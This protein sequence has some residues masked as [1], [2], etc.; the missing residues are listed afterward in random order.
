MPIQRALEQYLDP[1]SSLSRAKI[2]DPFGSFD[3]FDK[4]NGLSA[5]DGLG[6]PPTTKGSFP[7]AVTV[8]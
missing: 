5:V 2:I 3:P 4:N 6:K 7:D 8:E 1:W